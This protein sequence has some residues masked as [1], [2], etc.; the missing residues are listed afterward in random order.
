MLA[1]P[2]LTKVDNVEKFMKIRSQ[3]IAEN[4]QLNIGVQ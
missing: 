4:V 2:Y 1:E 3:N